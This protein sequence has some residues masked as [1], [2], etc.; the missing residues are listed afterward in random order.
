VEGKIT[1]SDA[2]QQQ[3][4]MQCVSHMMKDAMGALQPPAQ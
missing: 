4:A 1:P 2:E 3:Y